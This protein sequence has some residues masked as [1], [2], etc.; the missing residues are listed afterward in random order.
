MRMRCAGC[1]SSGKSATTGA[2]GFW[3]KGNVYIG[4]NKLSVAFDAPLISIK[5]DKPKDD[6]NSGSVSVGIYDKSTNEIINRSVVVLVT[7]VTLLN[8]TELKAQA[9]SSLSES[10]RL[11]KYVSFDNDLQNK[12]F[13]L[14]KGDNVAAEDFFY[15]RNLIK[16]LSFTAYD[17]MTSLKLSTIP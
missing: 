17:L 11:M 4:S 1:A 13:I 16:S 7:S 3:K 15:D 9:G 6:S 8:G 5:T 14:L 2:T 12:G 10:I